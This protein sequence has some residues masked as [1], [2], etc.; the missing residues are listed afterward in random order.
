M[1]VFEIDSYATRTY[2]VASVTRD[3]TEGEG[4]LRIIGGGRLRF[5]HESVKHLSCRTCRSEAMP[6]WNFFWVGS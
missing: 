2:A 4:M 1:G 5:L 6:C 3:M